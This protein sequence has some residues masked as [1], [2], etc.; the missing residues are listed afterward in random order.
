MVGCL[1]HRILRRCLLHTHPSLQPRCR[2]RQANSKLRGFLSLG[3]RPQRSLKIGQSLHG[4]PCGSRCRLQEGKS[5]PWHSSSTLASCCFSL[6]GFKA[7]LNAEKPLADIADQAGKA[8]KRRSEFPYSA[9]GEGSD[10]LLVLADLALEAAAKAAESTGSLPFPSTALSLQV[11]R[12]S[13]HHGPGILQ[14]A[15]P[16][17][18]AT[19]GAIAAADSVM[20]A[21][22]HL[23]SLSSPSNPS[24]GMDT[25]P[26]WADRRDSQHG[27]T[28]SFRVKPCVNSF[29]CGVCKYESSLAQCLLQK[30]S[31][32]VATATAK[33]LGAPSEKASRET[34]RVVACAAA[35]LARAHGAGARVAS[36]DLEG[37]RGWCCASLRQVRCPSR[38]RGRR[39]GRG[40]GCGPGPPFR[41]EGNERH[42][43]S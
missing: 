31:L 12:H 19:K 42:S 18:Q 40:R 41:G 13:Q 16:P 8:G 26:G 15:P 23:H 29:V 38:G 22:V 9:G 34:A 36:V 2:N 5:G 33:T 43:Q 7:L 21:S 30:C 10:V 1:L 14:G 32:E 20:E 35:Q 11:L 6:H 17:V 4:S 28:G 27:G 3:F 39:G 37:A 25:Q 24:K